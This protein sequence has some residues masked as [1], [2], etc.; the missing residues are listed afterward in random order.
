[1]LYV[2]IDFSNGVTI[3][4]LVDSG[5]YV[6]AIPEDELERKRTYSR[7]N[8]LKM[9]DP[10]LFQIQVA[11]GQL[12]KPTAIATIWFEIGDFEF[13]EHFVVMRNLT[14]PIIGLHFMQYNSA[15]VDIIHILLHFPHLSMQAKTADEWKTTKPQAV[16]VPEDNAVQ[17]MT[18][19]AISAYANHP[20]QFK[21]TGL[22]T[23]VKQYPETATLL[24]SHSMLIEKENPT[25]V[26]NV[27]DSPYTLKKNTQVAD[28]KLLT[29]KQ[30]KFIKPVDTAILQMLP[31]DDPDLTPYLNELLKSNKQESQETNFWFPTP[32][33]PGDIEEHSPIQSRDS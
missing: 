33:N 15:I 8:I 6:S 2:P 13:A 7:G 12:E 29:S 24:I 26:T 10:L 1:M 20:S 5:A 23:P 21:T 32:E 22:T 27:G 11:N 31:S 4:Y 16:T 30:S 28:F 14:G 19:N 18:T 25:R 3:D 9:G 17:P